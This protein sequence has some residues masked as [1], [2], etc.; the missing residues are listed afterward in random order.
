MNWE[1]VCVWGRRHAV[2]LSYMLLLV[3]Y[4]FLYYLNSLVPLYYGDDYVYSFIVGSDVGDW[5]FLWPLADDT[6]R[7][8]S[9]HDIFV[10]QYHHYFQWG[11]RIV[12]HTMVQ[13]LLWQGK[14]L[15]NL[16]NPL[17]NILLILLVYWISRGGRVSWR[18]DNPFRLLWIAVILWAL[19]PDYSSTNIWLTGSCNYLWTGVLQLAFILP[20]VRYIYQRESYWRDSWGMAALML[21]GGILAGWTNENTVGFFL[22]WLLG[23]AWRDYQEQALQRWQVAG[24]IG[25]VIGYALL[26]GAPG[27]IMR[28]HIAVRVGEVTGMLMKM[29]ELKTLLAALLF[30][31]L[32]W[33]FI[34]GGWWRRRYFGALHQAAA[35]LAQV[36]D[37]CGLSLGTLLIMMLAPEFPLRAAF[38]PSVL[39]LIAAATMLELMNATGR[40]RLERPVRRLLT[41]VGIIYMGFSLGATVYGYR[42]TQEWSAADAAQ[43]QRE[44]AEGRREIVLPHRE[45]PGIVVKTGH[46]GLYA[47][48]EDFNNWTN[49]D[50][51]LYLGHPEVKIRVAESD[52]EK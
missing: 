38:L 18:L 13:F 44:L 25:L 36:R 14:W 39:L 4:A 9:W 6:L 37:F 28:A 32:L 31:L 41:A 46:V 48:N 45:L 51:M 22:L 24:I 2:K 12:A 50:Y 16:L 3:L 8:A 33:Y 35:R 23:Y 1:A 30:Q 42:L 29:H 27:N 21:L 34:S 11:G 15:F 19:A 17:M 26:L 10:S 20:F 40:N 49:R 5:N 7:V 52:D 47:L 43:V